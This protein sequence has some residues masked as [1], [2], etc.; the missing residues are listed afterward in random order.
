MKCPHLYIVPGVITNA[1]EG[2]IP[3]QSILKNL[4]ER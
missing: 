1:E 3:V 4:L 2:N